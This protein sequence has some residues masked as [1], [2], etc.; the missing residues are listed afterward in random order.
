M[1]KKRTSKEVLHR[2]VERK[3]GEE[4]INITFRLTR[5][6]VDAFR[7]KCEKNS[8]AMAPVI[9]EMLRDFIEN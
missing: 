7:N 8:V 4:K 3:K 2:V 1:K 5:A 6:V 9:E